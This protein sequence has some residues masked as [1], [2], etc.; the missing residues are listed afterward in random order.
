MSVALHGIG[1]GGGIAIGRARLVSHAD[2][3]ITHY[4]LHPQNIA[5]EIIRFEEAIIQTRQELDLL[6]DRIPTQSPAELSAFIDLHMMLLQDH[7]IAREPIALIEQEQCN[8]EWALK[9][10]RD[11]LM[12]Q[13]DEIEDNYLRERSQDI[14]QVISRIFKALHGKH[15][16]P[17]VNIVNSQPTILVAHD[18]S[19]A[20][21]VMFKEAKFAAFMTDIGGPTSHTA[22]LARSLEIPAVIALRHAR[23]L[24]QDDEMI[25]VDSGSGVIIANPD[26]KTIAEYTI[27]Q[28]QYLNHA[29][30]LYR[31][32]H[33][34]AV[35]QDGTEVEVFANIESPEDT[36][37]ALENGAKGIG[38]FRSEFLFL[39]AEH[40]PDEEKQFVAYRQVVETMQNQPVIIRTL[41][42]GKDK[43]PKWDHLESHE[44]YSL[45]PALGLMGIRLCLAEPQIF[46]IQLRALLRAAYFGPIKLL[47]PMLS[48]VN[49]IT[50]TRQLIAQACD[51]LKADGLPFKQDVEL[52]GMIETPAAA[53]AITHFLQ[54]L[55]FVSIG[56]NDLI[57]YT[58][59][60]DR[61]D[62]A[63]SHLYNPLHPAI[64][65][66]L[67]HTI[68]A[69]N[70]HNT[71]VAICGEMA[72]DPFLTRLLLGIGL[73]RFSMLPAQLLKVK[74]Q[75]LDTN[76]SKIAPAIEAILTSCDAENT[77]TMIHALNHLPC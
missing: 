4:V 37:Y 47:L 18:L 25:I 54:A 76:L 51:S 67:H 57:Q 75:I 50:Q 22:I 3:E 42:L 9:L 8:A 62:D 7:A 29:K 74:R 48:H 39:S 61:S 2:I 15:T 45:N 24:I 63:V 14:M 36:V 55:D 72:G 5:A 26:A 20:D 66:L 19:P 49:E 44:N 33:T 21:L 64:L 34:P 11:A 65:Q 56:T 59:A 16:S 32:R 43:I 77:R 28:K 58:L 68:Q 52:G 31:I 35:T 30:T 69:A 27:R 1:I 10:Q 6:R 23:E 46:I 13:F 60:V 17:S 53:V 73:R 70:Q 71:P 40:L 41:D 12:K 38:L